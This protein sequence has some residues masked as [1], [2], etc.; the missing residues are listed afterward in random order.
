[1][2]ILVRNNKDDGGDNKDD[3]DDDDN[4]SWNST[5]RKVTAMNSIT[6]GSFLL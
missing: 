2:T 5:T 4:L 1:M 3:D 6:T